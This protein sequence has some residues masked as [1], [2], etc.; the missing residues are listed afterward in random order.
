[1]LAM[2]TD[3]T[4]VF[5]YNTSFQHGASALA[6]TNLCIEGCLLN[7]NKKTTHLLTMRLISL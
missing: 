6:V 7:R 4:Q 2:V 3:C 1:M 5:T